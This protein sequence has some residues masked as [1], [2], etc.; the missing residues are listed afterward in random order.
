[1]H[2]LCRSDVRCRLLLLCTDQKSGE[3]HR[4]LELEKVHGM[5]LLRDLLSV[6]RAEIPVAGNQPENREVRVLPGAPS[7]REAARMHERLPRASSGVWN[8]EREPRRSQTSLSGKSG[9]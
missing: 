8:E 6:S 9:Q 3:R 1:M 2:A 5:P 4:F 7:G